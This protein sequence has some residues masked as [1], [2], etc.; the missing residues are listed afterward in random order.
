MSK[1]VWEKA[2]EVIAKRANAKLIGAQQKTYPFTGLIVCGCCG[3]IYT[4][5]VNNSGTISQANFWKCRTAL[6]KGVA[7]C[8]NAGI[9]EKVLNDLFVECYNEFIT[10]GYHRV[11][12]DSGDDEQRLKELHDAEKE[13][14]KLMMGGMITRAQYSEEQQGIRIEMQE[15][16]SRMQESRYREVQGS[17]FSTIREFDE[18]KVYSFIRGVRIKNWT[19]TFEFYNGVEISR[20]YT[21]GKPGNIR[22]WK[23]KQMQRRREQENG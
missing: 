5:K 11:V 13:L 3:S 21:N 22:D 7:Y 19:V 16:K 10:K 14:T 1:D 12:K 17:N 9:K 8:N 6:K 20:T 18:Q 4:H 23:I 2:Q 15:I